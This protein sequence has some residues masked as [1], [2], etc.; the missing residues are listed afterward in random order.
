M[1]KNKIQLR[2][3]EMNK[4]SMIVLLLNSLCFFF[5]T[6]VDGKENNIRVMI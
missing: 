1:K 4:I 2:N 5:F 6:I 3:E